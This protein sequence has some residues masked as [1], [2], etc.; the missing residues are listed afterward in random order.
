CLYL[1][2]RPKVTRALR[3][4]RS[5]R[6]IARRRATASWSYGNFELD[7]AFAKTASGRAVE[8]SVETE[9]RQLNEEA[10]HDVEQDD[11]SRNPSAAADR[12]KRD[13]PFVDQRRDQAQALQCDGR[14]VGQ[15]ER[16][17]PDKHEQ[18]GLKNDRPVVSGD[19]I[20][21]ALFAPQPAAKRQ[22]GQ[23]KCRPADHIGD[24]LDEKDMAET[25]IRDILT[26]QF[27]PALEQ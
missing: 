6:A 25:R 16:E 13:E 4:R 17:Q 27:Q 3:S 5:G 18:R 1:R 2:H 22:R 26:R 7:Q 24:R 23:R 9:R 21:A 11:K 12:D 14:A 15:D 8:A 10:E 20:E 19:E